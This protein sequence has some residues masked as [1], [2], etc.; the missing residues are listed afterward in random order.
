VKRLRLLERVGFK[1]RVKK[2]LKE[3]VLALT[4]HARDE[5]AEYLE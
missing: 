4:D 5:V 2:K 1:I 3:L